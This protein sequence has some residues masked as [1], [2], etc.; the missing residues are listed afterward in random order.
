MAEARPSKKGSAT[1][2]TARQFDAVAVPL[3]EAKRNK[4]PK[5]APETVTKASDSVPEPTQR[6]NSVGTQTDEANNVPAE[7]AS[8][9][10]APNDARKENR[11]ENNNREANVNGPT[12]GSKRNGRGRGGAREQTN[13]HHAAEFAPYG[14]PPSPSVSGRGNHQFSFV[15]QGRGGWVRGNPRSQSIPYDAYYGRV[16]NP[17]PGHPQLPPV[18]T[19]IPGMYEYPGYPMTAIP[20]QPYMEQQYL[21]DM[22]TTQLEYYFSIDNQFYHNPIPSSLPTPGL[23]GLNRHPVPP[24]RQQPPPEIPQRTFPRF[25]RK[26]SFDH[27]VPKDGINQGPSGRHQYNGKPIPVDTISGI[28]RPADT[29]HSDSLLR[30]DPSHLSSSSF[31]SSS[32]NFSFPPYDGVFDLP[33][34]SHYPNYQRTS[35]RPTS[36]YPSTSTS[37][38]ANEGLS[39]AAVTASAVMA[40][41]YAQLNAVDE[42][43]LDYRQLMSL[44]Y[45]NVDN[46]LYTHVDPT[47]ILNTAAGPSSFPPFHASPSSDEWGNGPSSNASPEPYNASNASTPPSTE[48]TTSSRNP[49]KYISLQQTAQEVRKSL[50]GNSPGGTE[51]KSPA[52]TPEYSSSDQTTKQEDGAE[53]PPTLCT[54]CQTTNTPLWRRDP[55]GQPLCNACGLFYVR[56]FW[57]LWS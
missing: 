23:H 22:V 40:E 35:N 12:R 30:A 4:A 48:G 55:E 28:K 36:L 38:S 47:Q 9:R 52:S 45:P 21:M 44:G 17:Y 14:V 51:P 56:L 43:L 11:S 26:T 24:P 1:P 6:R 46:H 8:A 54:N 41:N 13:G 31:P 10:P 37:S 19:Y 25:V 3:P 20:Y 2:D 33:A 29:F 53:Q 49:R 7:S 57:L 16:A 15:Q 5:Q 34:N 18:Q 39:A 27:T 42:H 50:P 32:F